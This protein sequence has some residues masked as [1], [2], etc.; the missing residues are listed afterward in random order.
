LY[1][2]V[3]EKSASIN[4]SSS[5]SASS[6]KMAADGRPVDG[7]TIR[8]IE[9][10]SG[11]GGWSFA[12]QLAQHMNSALC[13]RVVRAVDI[14][15]VANEI[16]AYNSDVKPLAKSIESLNFRFIES[17]P[18]EMWVMSPPCQPFTRNH[19]TNPGDNR[20]QALDYI[21]KLLQ[22]IAADAA[23]AVL[24]KYIL[25]EN[26][27]GFES[28]AHCASLLAVLQTAGYGYKQFILTPTQFGIPNER[29]RYF[30]LAVKS[31]TF[32]AQN[33]Q[34]ETILT[35]LPQRDGQCSTPKLLKDYLQYDLPEQE[36][37]S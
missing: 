35:S 36:L 37:V 11:I 23:K 21:I 7:G 30:L 20:T 31:A 15:T 27:V 18:A 16:Y 4:S 10:F 2:T 22:Q 9:W 6:S 34:I 12:L 33:Q 32:R 5:S 8:V 14:N 29:P 13:F 28:S 1:R 26:V 19:E 24:P 3:M 25:L 17:N